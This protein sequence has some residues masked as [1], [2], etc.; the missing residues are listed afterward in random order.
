MQELQTSA[1]SGLAAKAYLTS[2][3]WFPLDDRWLFVRN[4]DLWHFYAYY[5]L[6]LGSNYPRG[7]R[8]LPSLASSR[9]V[10]AEENFWTLSHVNAFSFLSYFKEVTPLKDLDASTGVWLPSFSMKAAHL[11]PPSHLSLHALILI[12][13]KQDE[14]HDTGWLDLPDIDPQHGWPFCREYTESLPTVSDGFDWSQPPAQHA[15]VSKDA[16]ASLEVF[17]QEFMSESAPSLDGVRERSAHGRSEAAHPWTASPLAWQPPT[18]P[19]SMAQQLQPSNLEADS[20]TFALS[21]GSSLCSPASSAISLSALQQRRV[22]PERSLQ[23]TPRAASAPKHH[24]KCSIPL[25][26]EQSLQHPHYEYRT[27]QPSHTP[28]PPR[29]RSGQPK[30]LRSKPPPSP[31]RALRDQQVLQGRADG[32]TY[33]EIKH[34]YKMSEPESTLRGRWRNLQKPPE[35]RVRNPTWRD[36]DVSAFQALHGYRTFQLLEAGDASFFQSFARVIVV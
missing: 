32:L 24:E 21:E 16:D 17:S 30:Q 26:T 22:T 29:G 27:I 20:S 9:G 10:M 34:K 18:N 5:R 7:Q 11:T 33:S 6:L 2:G 14:S 15:A 36:E 4:A 31:V 3:A 23:S 12:I 8:A 1:G 28:L 25:Y 35:Q 19:A 13:C